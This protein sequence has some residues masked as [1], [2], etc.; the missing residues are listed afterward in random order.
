MFWWVAGGLALFYA[1][2]KNTAPGS[3]EVSGIE[4][5]DEPGRDDDRAAEVGGIEDADE[6]GRDDDEAAELGDD[7][8]DVGGEEEEART[9]PKPRG[10]PAPPP[11]PFG[12]GKRVPKDF[13][14]S[15]DDLKSDVDEESSGDL[16]TEGDGS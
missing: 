16:D 8:P 11:N 6:A 12:D 4:D 3:S 2:W 5:A 14:G 7:I 1:F 9:A 15:Y 13:R 10:L